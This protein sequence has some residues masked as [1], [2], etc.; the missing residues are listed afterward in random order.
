MGYNTVGCILILGDVDGFI[1]VH[2]HKFHCFREQLVKI[3]SNYAI[4]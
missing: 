3:A 4:G 1:I 2:I